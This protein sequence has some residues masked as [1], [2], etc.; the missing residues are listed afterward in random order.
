MMAQK[1]ETLSGWQDGRWWGGGGSETKKNSKGRWEASNEGPREAKEK[2]DMAARRWEFGAGRW[3]IAADLRE[4]AACK[5]KKAA[6]L[7]ELTVT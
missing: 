2:V 1:T 3:E 6:G 5:G 4:R 7:R